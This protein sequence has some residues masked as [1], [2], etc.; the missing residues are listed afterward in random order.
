[1]AHDARPVARDPQRVE[2]VATAAT[3][4]VDR[5]PAPSTAPVAAKPADPATPV[6]LAPPAEPADLGLVADMQLALRQGDPRRALAAVHEH[7]VRFPAS[8]LA[9][10][11]EG[12]KAIALCAGASPRDAARIGGAFVDAHPRSTLLA[13]IR[14]ACGVRDAGD[15]LDTD[16]EGSGQ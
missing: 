9:P 4:V 16:R 7:E 10:E 13:R 1:V 3:R 12:V 11:R 8:E 2:A 15:D 6:R 5:A 14:A